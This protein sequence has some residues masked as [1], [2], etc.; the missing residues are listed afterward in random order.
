[1]RTTSLKRS[2]YNPQNTRTGRKI[3]PLVISFFSSAM[4]FLK[5]LKHEDPN[6]G[7]TMCLMALTMITLISSA[8]IANPRR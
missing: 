5:G 7:F 6:T 2:I 3:N 1:M 4:L 8:I